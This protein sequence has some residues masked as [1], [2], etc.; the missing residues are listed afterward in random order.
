M[1]LTWWWYRHE[2]IFTYNS[3]EPKS[4][5]AFDLFNFFRAADLV[6]SEDSSG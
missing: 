5:T 3:K 1:V 4:V 2:G 6:Q